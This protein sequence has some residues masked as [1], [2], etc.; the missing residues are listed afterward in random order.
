[1]PAIVVAVAQLDEDGGDSVLDDDGGR[2]SGSRRW[3]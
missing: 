3:R 1:V 2:S